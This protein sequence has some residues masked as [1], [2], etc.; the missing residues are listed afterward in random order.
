MKRA[1]RVAAVALLAA[2]ALAVLHGPARALR[3][4]LLADRAVRELGDALDAQL[5]RTGRCP[6][7][8]SLG[9][10]ELA[11]W[12][13]ASGDLPTVPLNPDTGA[14]FGSVDLE[15]DLLFYEPLPGARG[16]RLEVLDATGER[17]VAVRVG[18]RP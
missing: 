7:V 14:P 4:Q 6:D 18:M 12:L 3:R 1:G 10:A 5:A 15:T 13:H 2:C 16:Y 8:P 17:V 9:G 11:L